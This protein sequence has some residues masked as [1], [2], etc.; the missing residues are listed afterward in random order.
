MSG[1]RVRVMVFNTIFQLYVCYIVVVSSG[2]LGL[3]IL[4]ARRKRGPT[5]I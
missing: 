1:V 3:K 2:G 5:Y 4:V